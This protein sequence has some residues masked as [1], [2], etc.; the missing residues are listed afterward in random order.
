MLGSVVEVLVVEV[1]MLNTVKVEDVTTIR[2]A[3]MEVLEKE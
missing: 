1:A 2:E 3:V